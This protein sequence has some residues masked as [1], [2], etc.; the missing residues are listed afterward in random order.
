[1][2]EAIDLDWPHDIRHNRVQA[3]GMAFYQTW[4]EHLPE[5]RRW[6]FWPEDEPIEYS[7]KE[8]IM[9]LLV[10]AKHIDERFPLV[11]TGRS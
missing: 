6:L 8:L 1:M 9:P 5:L 7:E 4:I 3:L 10:N 2:I 11:Q